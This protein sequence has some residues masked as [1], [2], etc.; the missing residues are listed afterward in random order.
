M[1]NTI[2][3]IAILAIAALSGYNYVQNKMI[4]NKSIG[5]IPTIESKINKEEISKFILENPNV[6]IESLENY[7]VKMMQEQEDL[8]KSQIKENAD[9]IYTENSFVIGNPDAEIKLVEFF[10]YNCGYCKKAA[11]ILKEL[12]KKNPNVKIYMKDMPILSESSV[13]AA[14][15]SV[16]AGL[17]GKYEEFSF[18]L[19]KKEGPLNEEVFRA[20]AAEIE[21]DPNE[22]I[23]MTNSEKVVEILMDNRMAASLI[24]LKGT[25]TILIETDLYNGEFSIEG[26]EKAIR[27]KLE[28]IM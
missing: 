14:K 16:A 27:E 12:V 1:K 15:A 3:T 7:K 23:E 19:M 24:G 2:S 28:E 20:I 13:E 26:F 10:D 11:N 17:L 22:L 8:I 5:S 18:A 4:N 21:L 9:K 25:P 6:I